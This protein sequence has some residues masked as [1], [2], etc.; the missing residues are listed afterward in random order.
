MRALTRSALLVFV[1]AVS[2]CIAADAS[3]APAQPIPFSHKVHAGASIRCNLCHPNAAKAERAS[4]PTASQCMV[5][6][7]GIKKDSP[8]IRDLAAFH[9]QGKPIPWVR[10]YRL[11]DFVFFSHSTHIKGKVQCAECHG[12]VEQRDVLTAEI[13]HNMKTCMACHSAR[14]A[15]NKCHVCHELGQ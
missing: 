14:G 10:V 8:S 7:A 2:V 5:C 15:S 3:T 9:K 11:S 1:A 13:K 4:L 6:H 12:P